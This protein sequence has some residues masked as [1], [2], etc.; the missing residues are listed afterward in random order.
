MVSVYDSRKVL[1]RPF[2][3]LALL[4]QKVQDTHAFQL[5]EVNTV[6]VIHILH[7]PYS[8]SLATV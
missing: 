8:K 2:W 5:K 1:V 7:S 3:K 6:L 4:V